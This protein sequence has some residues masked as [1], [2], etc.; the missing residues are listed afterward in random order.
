MV[1]VECVLFHRDLSRVDHFSTRSTAKEQ[2]VENK[3]LS[4]DAKA[5]TM[6]C[7]NNVFSGEKPVDNI[8]G[9]EY[10]RMRVSLIEFGG[11]CAVR[12]K[13]SNPK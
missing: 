6:V 3:Q 10:S 1:A 8:S 12:G 5:T 9:A 7:P 2:W 13:N 11:K 4:G